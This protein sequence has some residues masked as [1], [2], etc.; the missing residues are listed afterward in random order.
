MKLNVCDIYEYSLEDVMPD[1]S[2]P[3]AVTGFQTTL[4]AYDPTAPT[5]AELS[6]DEIKELLSRHLLPHVWNKCFYYSTSDVAVSEKEEGLVNRVR[7]A[8]SWLISSYDKYKPILDAYSTEK[9]QLTAQLSET[10][11]NGGTI[12]DTFTRDTTSTGTSS[13]TSTDTNTD[14]S[15][16]SD[17][18]VSASLGDVGDEDVAS[19]RTQ[20]TG[21]GTTT[22]SG[23]TSGTGHTADS[24]TKTD[25]RTKSH[26]KDV[27]TAMARLDEI[28]RLY[29]STYERW[30]DEFIKEFIIF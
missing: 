4:T 5:Q 9:N 25:S 29:K 6:S 2:S 30:A 16:R 7:Q 27:A 19:G 11:A 13:G 3:F 26:S 21:N 14:S 8:A 20:S 1:F 17:M 28:Q 12:T 15:M 18:P 10:Y 23:T 24:R 22:D